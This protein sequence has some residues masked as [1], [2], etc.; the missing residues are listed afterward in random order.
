MT[1]EPPAPKPRTPAQLASDK[2]QRKKI[3]PDDASKKRKKRYVEGASLKS[4]GKWTDNVTFPGR[5]FDDLDEY[6]TAKK[7]HAAQRSAYLD[8]T[9]MSRHGS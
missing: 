9:R 1:V 8:Q 6:R 5:E 7:Q 4:N 3:K 2:R